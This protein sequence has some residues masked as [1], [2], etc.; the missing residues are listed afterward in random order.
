LAHAALSVNQACPAAKP[1][2]NF[3]VAIAS[4]LEGAGM[5]T[6]V[7][8]G[9]IVA[10]FLAT[11]VGFAEEGPKN[12]KILPK[13]MSKADIKKLMK[14]QA[15]ALGVQCDFCHD[16]DDFAKDT[17][18]KELARTMMLMTNQINKDNFKGKSV[19]GCIT[20]HNGQKEPK[21]LMKP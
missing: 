17:E 21:T 1:P 16:T 19:V 12:L 8:L 20:C 4:T 7:L 9:L 6:H 15:A 18:K 3:R 2:L 5:R 11:A 10:G 14:V 13:T